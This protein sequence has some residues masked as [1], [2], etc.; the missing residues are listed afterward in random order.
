M[1]KRNL[2]AGNTA[3]LGNRYEQL[4]DQKNPFDNHVKN[5]AR[6]QIVELLKKSISYSKECFCSQ[7]FADT[8]D[9]LSLVD[10]NY[11][12]IKNILCKK[13]GT[14][15]IDPLPENDFYNIVYSTLYWKLLHGNVD[16]T[17]NRFA[18][19]VKR[20]IPFSDYLKRTCSLKSK[21]V[22]EIGAS[23]GAGL[24]VLKNQDCR[25]LVGYDYDKEFI[26][27]G[28]EF[29][30]VDLRI[31]GISDAVN[32]GV[33]YDI[34]IL[35]HVLEHFHNPLKELEELHKII[36][37][38]GFLF[39]EVPGVFNLNYW[40]IDPMMYFDIFHPFSFSLNTL[41]ML[42]NM[43]G[44]SLYDGNNHIYS[45]WKKDISLIGT[46]KIFH[47]EYLNIKNHLI[48]SELHRMKIEE[49]ENSIVGKIIRVCSNY[50]K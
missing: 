6:R 44:Y 36:S 49:F 16:L 9:V 48:N 41:T 25:C 20:A 46:C 18:L 1:K 29:S 13:C 28:I 23:Y 43:S 40:T 15:R 8:Y 27:K 21:N 3:I 11:L 10:K 14:I 24:F 2:I 5:E 42:M 38:N 17:R 39:V 30:G 31:G 26:E 4:P 45:L 32:D 47:N 22:L 35:R 33:K 34:I 50:L 12:L 19:S 7:A 37:D